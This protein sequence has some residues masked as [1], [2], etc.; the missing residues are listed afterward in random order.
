MDTTMKTDMDNDG[1][2]PWM[3]DG[4]RI[5]TT[6]KDSNGDSKKHQNNEDRKLPRWMCFLN[7]AT[8]QQ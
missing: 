3:D 7:I 2:A 1:I 5:V 8:A 4:T 6:I